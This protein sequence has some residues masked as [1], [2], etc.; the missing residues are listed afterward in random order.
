M[1][2][3]EDPRIYRRVVRDLRQV[4]AALTAHGCHVEPFNPVA[5]D[6]VLEV[7]LAEE[8][9]RLRALGERDE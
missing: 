4:L 6:V 2:V 5:P 1:T 7:R 9:R 8:S 3:T